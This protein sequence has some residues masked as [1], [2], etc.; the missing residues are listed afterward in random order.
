[1]STKTPFVI[2]PNQLFK[3]TTALASVDEVYLIEETLFFKEFK[4]N[5]K[6]LILHRAS[7]R[8]Y[9]DYLRRKRISVNYIETTSRDSDIRNLLACLKK[10]SIHNFTHYD[11]C[12]NWLEKRILESCEKLSINRTEIPTPLFLNTKKDLDTY[13]L[14]RDRFSQADFYIQQRKTRNILMDEQEKPVGGK[15]SFDKENRL[16]YPKKKS[17]PSLWT[18]KK[19]E[20]HT[21]AESYVDKYFSDNYG[22]I[23]DS[24]FFPVTHEDSE[25]WLEC[26]L[27]ERFSEFG[28]YEDAIVAG[29]T[30]LNH[31][32]LTPMLNIGLLTPQKVVSDV[33]N[34]ASENNVPLNSL[35]GFIRQIVG[36]REFIRGVYVFAGSKIRSS[37]YWGFKAPLPNSLYDATT[38]IAPLDDSIRKS[39]E[40]GYCHHIERLMVLGNYMLLIECDPNQVYRWFMEMFVDAY[41]WVMVPNVYSMSQFADGGVLATKPY[42][43]GSNYI[44]KMSNYKKADWCQ[45]WDALFWSFMNTHR[46]RLGKNPR[47]AMLL[48]TFERF[49]DNKKRGMYEI[50]KSIIENR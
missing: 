35:E 8:Y 29:E 42:I 32:V 24:N 40:S 4:F 12:D 33:L 34:F 6:K 13:F 27:V 19:N 48:K 43:S 9:A 14:R 31:S 5:K 2:F 38:G 44:L 22:S 7:M 20:Y 26:F 15:W 16:K 25:K 30:F 47:L 17:A 45:E 28:A 46:D 37:N 10:N 36:W 3:D 21:E 18:P 1:M 23:K 11:V 50:A 39:L 41:D 49:D